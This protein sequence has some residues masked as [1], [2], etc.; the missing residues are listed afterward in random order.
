[1]KKSIWKI[2]SK[3]GGRTLLTKVVTLVTVVS[4]V[5]GTATYI[6]KTNNKQDVQVAT[7]SESS[8]EPDEVETSLSNEK[9]ESETPK[10]NEDSSEKEQKV[11]L[12]E[13]DTKVIGNE[14]VKEV[15][16]TKENIKTSE[17][18]SQ[19]DQK[20]QEQ[21]KPTPVE[22]KP[23][24]PTKPAPVE[25]PKPAPAPAPK[26]VEQPKPA[27]APAPKP[28]RESGIDWEL[29]NKFNALSFN[30]PYNV[31]PM[32]YSYMYKD[33]A[34]KSADLVKLAQSLAFGGEVDAKFKTPWVPRS[35][36]PNLTHVYMGHTVNVVSGT[37]EY[38]YRGYK[39]ISNNVGFD[40]C[41]AYW[42]KSIN[43][44]KLYYVRIKLA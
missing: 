7:N 3:I 27:P 23:Q 5:G 21:L 12:S 18:P 39:D 42:D 33:G 30:N 16:D 34:I 2:I 43:N 32:N 35:A 9:T 4:I 13:K 25:Q 37:N 41:V 24:T 28:V 20:T 1:M 6:Y 14:D 11:E 15:V 38:S 26:P 29:T 36:T 10:T 22:T 40:Y 19:E 31:G 44:Y 17:K 8:K